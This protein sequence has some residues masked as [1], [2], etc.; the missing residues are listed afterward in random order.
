MPRFLCVPVRAMT[1]ATDDVPFYT[2]GQLSLFEDRQEGLGGYRTAR[3]F[4]KGRFLGH[5]F[6]VLQTEA[7]YF[8]GDIDVVGQLFG[9]QLIAFAEAGNVYDSLGDALGDPRFGEMKA[10][11][12]GG[13]AI[14]WNLNTIIYICP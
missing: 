4:K 8:V 7:R 11:Y 6:T 3:G 2:M 13:I 5:A 14:P 9:L 1:N 10:S 12:G